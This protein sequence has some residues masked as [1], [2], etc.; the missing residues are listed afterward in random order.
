MGQTKSIKKA[1]LRIPDL[2]TSIMIPMIVAV[3]Q[4]NN[5]R[6]CNVPDCFQHEF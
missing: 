4:V 5:W 2:T 1:F 6:I 3:E